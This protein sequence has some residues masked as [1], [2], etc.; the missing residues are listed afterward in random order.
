MK[1]QFEIFNPKN[2]RFWL[3]IGLMLSA[4]AV[5]VI[6]TIIHSNG[7]AFIQNNQFYITITE[8]HNNQVFYEHTYFEISG[9][10][11]GGIPSK[12]F[13]WDKDYNVGALCG[14]SGNRFYKQFNS[15]DFARGKHVLCVQAISTDGKLSNIATVSIEI[16][17][18]SVTVSTAT[19]YMSDS[20]PDPLRTIFRPVESAARQLI[21][22][23]TGGTDPQDLN[24]D[25]IP[26]V[27][28]ISPVSPPYNPY[29]IPITFTLI[30]IGLLIL[31]VL[32]V[33]VTKNLV[34]SYISKKYAHEEKIAASPEARKYELEKLKLQLKIAKEQA[35]PKRIKQLEERIAKLEKQIKQPIIIKL[36]SKKIKKIKEEK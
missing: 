21:V 7:F 28:Q 32:I 11:L 9:Y 13:V 34:T 15:D 30:A 12:V 19:G 16:R 5:I 23:I 2:K 36:G 4:L 22:L 31:I 17:K 20:F 10:T 29:G 27:Y 8:P 1:S 24:G 26:D 33:Y 25:N 35:N 18:P 3:L 14:I 6:G